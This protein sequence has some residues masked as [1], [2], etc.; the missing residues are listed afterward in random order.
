MRRAC[1]CIS[2]ELVCCWSLQPRFNFPPSL[3]LVL[4]WEANIEL[5]SYDFNF[6]R[7]RLDIACEVA[8][9]LTGMGRPPIEKSSAPTHVVER[10]RWQG[11]WPSEGAQGKDIFLSLGSPILSAGIRFKETLSHHIPHET[12]RRAAYG[13]YGKE[14]STTYSAYDRASD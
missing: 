3:H 8:S 11:L 9:G 4:K 6:W 5:L 1:H 12:Q 14:I 13:N 10:P 7:Y 2:T